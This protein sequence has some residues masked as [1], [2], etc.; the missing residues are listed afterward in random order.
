MF[1]VA[2]FAAGFY[3]NNTPRTDIG[4]AEAGEVLGDRFGNAAKIIWAIGLLAAG[5]SSTMTGTFAGQFVMQGF[6]NLKISPWLRTTITRLFAIVPTM[7]VALLFAKNLD[8]LDQGLNILQSIQLPFA[9]IPL[10]TFSSSGTIL[11]SFRLQWKVR[12]SS[13][14]FLTWVV[15]RSLLGHCPWDHRHQHLSYDHKSSGNVSVSCW[16]IDSGSVWIDL[17]GRCVVSDD[18]QGLQETS[19]PQSLGS[20][21]RTHARGGIG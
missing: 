21:N 19:L 15:E 8:A 14:G 17:L 5:Q 11:S 3:I 2:V 16:S 9:L 10:L 6:L 18:I 1:I 20:R 7:I 4:L 12:T 13:S